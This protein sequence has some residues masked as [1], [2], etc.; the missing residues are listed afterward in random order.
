M[1]KRIL[2]ALSVAVMAS[3]SDDEAAPQD[4]VAGSQEQSQ[5]GMGQGFGAAQAGG[6]M[7]QSV[8]GMPGAPS[9]PGGNT[10]LPGVVNPN[11]NKPGGISGAVGSAVAGQAAAQAQSQA[12]AASSNKHYVRTWQLNVRSGPGLK[13]KPVH[14]VKFNEA[15]S[16]HEVVA[17]GRWVK[18]GEGKY[19]SAKFLSPT[20]NA[21]A[22]N[23]PKPAAPKTAH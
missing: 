4:P 13:F 1:M 19:V 7:G 9:L 11:A 14:T 18:I 22:W 3:C 16:V 15:V 8:P 21:K 10:Q 12:A 20:L 6:G 2:F 17:G 5:G 23:P